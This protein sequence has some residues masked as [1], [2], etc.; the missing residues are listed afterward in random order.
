MV[1]KL[2]LFNVLNFYS[3]SIAVPSVYQER[4]MYNTWYLASI[5]LKA[6]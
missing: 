6:P 2:L 5:Y 4:A 3:I 1:L